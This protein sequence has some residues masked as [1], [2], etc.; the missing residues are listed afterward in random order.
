MLVFYYFLIWTYEM[1]KDPKM[2]NI[3]I[4]GLIYLALVSQSSQAVD[5]NWACD[6]DSWDKPACWNPTGQP[7]H[8]DDAYLKQNDAADREI[9]SKPGNATF[10]QTD[11]SN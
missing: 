4:T 11:G 8:G 9:I 1:S 5:K 2:K 3:L 6:N 10:N 7:L